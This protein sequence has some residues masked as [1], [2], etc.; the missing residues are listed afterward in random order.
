MM[1]VPAM[2]HGGNFFAQNR[3]CAMRGRVIGVKKKCAV[4]EALSNALQAKRSSSRHRGARA[5][6]FCVREES[7]CLKQFPAHASLQ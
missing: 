4:V 6:C 3:V 5:P 1:A 2:R 7:A